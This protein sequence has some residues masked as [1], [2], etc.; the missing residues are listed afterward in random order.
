MISNGRFA[1]NV[2]GGWNAPEM[3]MFGAP[4]REHDQRYEYL[5]EW[6]E[7]IRKLW[8]ETEEFDHSGEF[9]NVIRG[10]SLPKPVQR[11][12]PPIMNAGGSPR[13]RRFAAQHA[14]LCFVVLTSEDVDDIRRQVDGYKRLAEE[15]FGRTVQ[16]WTHTYVVQR[17][18]QKE[19][20]AYL[21]RFAVEYED[22][23][24][25]DAWMKLQAEQAQLLP[26]EALA[27]F[28]LRFTAG[29]GGFPLVGTA[30]HI[31]DRLALLAE[32]G[33]DGVLLTWVDYYDGL[34]RFN[35]DVLPALEKLGLRDPFTP[36]NGSLG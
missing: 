18:T 35:A 8:V 20:D 22:V 25:V 30:E 12:Y 1:M 19:A 5:A 14:D 32:G 16:V 6:L 2:V 26:P 3:E 21:H 11:P 15:E 17:D 24:S 29:A 4:L 13:G 9:F 23:E 27:A 36:A 28:R 33:I 10:S 34:E 31:T 7:I